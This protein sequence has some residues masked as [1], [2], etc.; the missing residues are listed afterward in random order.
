M[1]SK[2]LKSH[3]LISSDL[4]DQEFTSCNGEAVSMEGNDL[5]VLRTDTAGERKARILNVREGVHL[6]SFFKKSMDSTHLSTNDAIIT[7]Y[8]ISRPFF[9]DD[10]QAKQRGVRTPEHPDEIEWNEV[11]NFGS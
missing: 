11:E 1:S 2:V 8:S 10:E 4:S 3:I 9:E 6:S 5:L 7:V